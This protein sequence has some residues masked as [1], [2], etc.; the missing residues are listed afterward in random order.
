MKR[1]RKAIPQ[2]EAEMFREILANEGIEAK[3]IPTKIAFFD[4][5]YFGI[6]A[7]VD[8]SVGDEDFDKAFEV[9]EHMTGERG[10]EEDDTTEEHGST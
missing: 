7:M 9:L 2:F 6:G 10:K 5:V 4:S 8:L 3:I 1:L